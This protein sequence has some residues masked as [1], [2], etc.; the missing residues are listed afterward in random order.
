MEDL[1]RNSLLYL[2]LRAEH[3]EVLKHKWL[4]SEKKGRDIGFD[5]AMV[6]W[7]LKHRSNWRRWWRQRQS[8]P[9]SGN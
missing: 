5:I 2:E 8:L 4:E 3:E 6:D 9:N 7:R 1:L